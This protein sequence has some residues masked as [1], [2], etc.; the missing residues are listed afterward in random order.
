MKLNGFEILRHPGRGADGQKDLIVRE[1]RLG[2]GGKSTIDW[3]V[4]CKHYAHSG[5]SITLNIEF[6]ITDR[7][8]RHNC[9][10][11]MGFYS[12]IQSSPL[13][14]KLFEIEDFEKLI[15][16]NSRIED[17][18]ISKKQNSKL[19]RRYFPES[20]SKISKNNN[21]YS[22]QDTNNTKENSFSSQKTMLEINI[23][24]LIIMEI[25]NMRFSYGESSWEKRNEILVELNKFTRR[26]NPDITDNI[27]DFLVGIKPGNLY[28]ISF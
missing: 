9:Q 12:T 20:Y 19:I 7:L 4:S 6:D 25:D 3:L 17:I 11:F 8:K 16:D 15:Y 27:I 14:D 2:E 24:A 10:G 1:T 26:I 22:T 23:T 18:L 5:K 13:S 21:S 28:L